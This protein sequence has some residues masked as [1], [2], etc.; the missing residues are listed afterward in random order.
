M[1][2]RKFFRSN[3]GRVRAVNRFLK[4]TQE[5]SKKNNKQKIKSDQ[6]GKLDKKVTDINL[7]VFICLN[8]ILWEN[9]IR[10]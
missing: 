8:V 5:M 4:K 2:K 7:D 1:N 10:R 6:F 9:Y 3:H